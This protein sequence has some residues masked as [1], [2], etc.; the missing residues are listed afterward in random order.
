MGPPIRPVCTLSA[1]LIATKNLQIPLE[2]CVFLVYDPLWEAIFSIVCFIAWLRGEIS[3]FL[4]RIWP[5]FVQKCSPHSVL[6]KRK[7]MQHMFRLPTL[8]AKQH[9]FGTIPCSASRHD[10]VLMQSPASDCMLP[11]A[12]RKLYAEH[13]LKGGGVP[14]PEGLQL[15]E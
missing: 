9:H 6:Q 8:Q 13:R 5:H 3:I 7:L 11:C 1:T 10:F 2:K 14:S 15:I 12:D 4:H